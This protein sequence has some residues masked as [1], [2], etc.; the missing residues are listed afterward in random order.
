MAESSP[1]DG[2]KQSSSDGP[3]RRR[4]II[5]VGL[6]LGMMITAME[7]TVVSTAMPTVIGALHG[8]QLYPWV[9]SAYLLA[10]TTTVPIYGK[11]A[12]LFGR[13]RVFLFATALFLIGSM[14]S[15]AAHSMPQLI[16]FRA[17]QGLGAGGVLPITLTIIGDLYS[18][19]ERPRVQALFTSM[20]GV[21]S[22]GGPVI[23]AFITEAF[24]WRWVFYVNLPI[25]LVS[26]LLVGLFLK[27]SG[28][29]TSGSRINV[30][31]LLL[32]SG[33]VV[34]LLAWLLQGGSNGRWLSP[35]MLALLGV[36]LALSTAFVWQERRAA[37]PMLP[38]ILFTNPILASTTI[39]NLLIGVM[40]Y[41]V[42]SYMPLF[43]QGVRGGNAHSASQVLTPLV[44]AWSL[45]AYVGG[46]A[47]VRFGFRPV[48][49][50]G[51]ACMMVASASMA[52]MTATTATTV[53]VLTMVLLGIGLGFC[54]MTFL[55][56]A[57]NAVPWNQRG[58]VTAASQFFRSMSGTL[59]VGALGAV[60]NAQMPV[61][62][63]TRSGAKVGPNALLNAAARA[64]LSPETLRAAQAGLAGGLHWVFLLMAALA[65]IA[66]ARI[67][68]IMAGRKASLLETEATAHSEDSGRDAGLR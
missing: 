33:S 61:G 31:G 66:G 54:S 51:I 55:V 21:S 43:M 24:S 12:D 22:L 35:P 34:G 56:T 1:T 9:F 52:L 13:R 44:L 2:A 28:R 64:T 14:L 41:A 3:S 18:L 59:G 5:T 16:F 17:I 49:A 19:H 7:S 29:Q 25:G 58:V 39:G 11:V 4:A 15:G 6:M 30:A 48:A 62:L 23:G 46:K 47:L 68:V 36:T 42:D 37:E 45:S 67:L 10:S 27:E 50:V 40:L 8:I 57:Q 60:L 20:W 63:V 65:W 32:F 38:P 53:I 26:A